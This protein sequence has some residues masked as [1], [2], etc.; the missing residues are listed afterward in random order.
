MD[1]EEVVAGY[2]ARATRV[3]TKCGEGVMVWRG[4]GEGPPVVLLHGAQGAWSHFI[5]NIDALAATR[6][7]WAADLPGY[8]ESALPAAPEHAAISEALALGLR[9]ILGKKL[10]VD[11]VGF[12]FGGVAGAYFASL[13]PQFVRRLVLVGTGGLNTPMGQIQL[14]RVRGLEGDA[15]QAALRAN[16]LALMLHAPEAADELALHLQVTNGLVSRLD[17]IKL[18]LPDRLLAVL[19]EVHVQV[20]AIWGEHDAPHPNPPAQEAVL[21]RFWPEMDFRTIPAAGHWAM[22]ENPEFFNATIME[23]LNKALR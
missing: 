8:G 1:A 7:V 23:L 21:R 18:V 3:E 22:Y 20:D 13:Y 12:S 14:Q 11:V 10:P 5:R 6:S 15:R 2:D 17:P 16:L 19:P 4:W 9:E